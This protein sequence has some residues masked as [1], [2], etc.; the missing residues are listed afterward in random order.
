MPPPRVVAFLFFLLTFCSRQSLATLSVSPEDSITFRPDA[1]RL[2]VE[3]MK[4]FAAGQFDSAA[5]LFARHIK[6]FPRSH[7][8]TGSYIMGAKAYYR[9]GS[10]RESIR[11]LKD[12]IDLY[13]ES[14]YLDDAHYTL[15]L[16]YYRTARYEDAADEFLQC[17]QQTGETKLRSRSQGML[18]IITSSNLSA[19]QLQLLL[20]DVTSDEIKALVELRTAEKVYSSGDVKS[21][22]EMLRS[23]ASR[24]PAIKY[25]GEALTLLQKYE[26]GGIL[27]IGVVLPLMLKAE[28]SSAKELGIELLDGIRFAVD[29][30]NQESLHR[31]EL[32]IR[33]SD[34]DPSM[35]ARQVAELCSDDKI[36]SILGPV[37]SNEAFASAGIAQARGV[38]LI[39][40]TATANGIA[41]IGAFIFQANPD[42]EM[43]GRAMARYALQQL[44][45]STVAV[46]SPI[47][48]PG[49]LMADAFVDEVKAQGGG[50]VDVQWYQAGATD[51]RVQLETMRRKALEMAAV[52]YVDFSKGIKH[53]DINKM[54]IW[55]LS[56]KFLDS[57]MEVGGSASVDFM[58]GKNGKQIADSL[59]LETQNPIVRAD[60][61]GLPVQNIQAMFIPISNPDEIGVVGPQLRFFN[62]QTQILGTGEWQD[63]TELD[64]HRQYVDGVIFSTDSDWDEKD[65][66]FKLFMAKFQK[67]QKKK[68]TKNTLYGYD[69]MMVLLSVIRKGA[70]HKNEIAS[71]LSMVQDYKG[72]HSKI[73]FVEKRVNSFFAILQYRGRLT[74]RI[75]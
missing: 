18:E 59:G 1:E 29:E 24:S 4:H 25:V 7:R 11:F 31:V 20:A 51:L 34:R 45:D 26:Q 9:L 46:L 32:D 48:P 39:T 50:I 30:H 56:Q 55:G 68:P 38:P 64:Q 23:I 41:S 66:S 13:P 35:A 58:F 36:V 16:D 61:L 42:Y 12:L 8:S 22:Q 75:G 53:S 57:M 19:A 40:P 6:E 28:K 67:A 69:A 15:G 27:R 33:D 21:A 73:S 44:K 62:F 10:F 60:S 43:R 71:K 2:F 74:R 14:K 52:P 63:P 37:F 5:S 54:V 65:Q 17:Y 70:S 47:E 3:A 49:K 72:I